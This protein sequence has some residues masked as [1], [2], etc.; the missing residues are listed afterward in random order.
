MAKN[1]KDAYNAVGST[2][3]L[4][5]DPDTLLIVTEKGHPLYDERA[6]EEPSESMVLNI[7]H[8]GV[9]QPITVRKNVETGAVEVVYG[10][11]RVKAA[12]VAN[13]RLRARGEPIKLVQAKVTRA[14]DRQVSAMIVIEN[15]IRRDDSPMNRAQ[16]IV[17]LREQ[18]GMPDEEIAIVFGCTTATIRNTVTLLDCTAVV[19]NA[20]ESG[21]ITLQIA[22]KLAKME[23]AEQREKLAE[24]LVSSDGKTGHA[25]SK[26][27]RK[28]TG[29]QTVKT[30]SRREVEEMMAKCHGEAACALAW[31]LGNDDTDFA[32]PLSE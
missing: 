22:S 1:S 8:Y 4:S 2:S 10:R 7:E 27:I 9:V 30:R 25:R 20:V 29:V 12:R 31:V 28:A 5:F 21:K 18:C 6:F 13:T 11:Q 14:D 24:A 16:K 23:P 17:R 26:A 3:L 32:K 19:R 15:E